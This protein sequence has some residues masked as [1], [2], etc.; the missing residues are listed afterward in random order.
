MQARITTLRHSQHHHEPPP[1]NHPTRPGHQSPM[2]QER[3]EGEPL[4]SGP[5]PRWGDDA[6]RKGTVCL[7][8]TDLAGAGTSRSCQPTLHHPRERPC[9][10]KH[11]QGDG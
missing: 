3:G 5:P 9:R 10:L 8:G 1:S 4:T 6:S 11:L 7:A 2:W